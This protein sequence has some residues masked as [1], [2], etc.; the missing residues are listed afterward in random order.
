M[1]TPRHVIDEYMKAS[2]NLMKLNDLTDAE[3]EVVEEMLGRLSE[4][5]SEH[6]QR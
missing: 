4:M 5:L 6:R 3:T 2:E 1:S